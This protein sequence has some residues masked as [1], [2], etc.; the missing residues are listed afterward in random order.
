MSYLTPYYQNKA[1]AGQTYTTVT[2]QTAAAGNFPFL[3]IF[4][5]SG[6]GKTLYVYAADY[7]GP[8]S[9]QVYLCAI[10]AALSGGGQPRINKL[11][12]GPVSIA[13]AVGGSLS[14]I[15]SNVIAVGSA[16]QFKIEN[17]VNF[18]D[19]FICPPGNGLALL[20]NAAASSGLF[21]F[22]WVEE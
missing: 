17:I 5:P 3:S 2:N 10:T 13:S 8:S 18:N 16:Q 11:P 7:S 22:T 9:L 14:V 20:N 6:S 12:G 19:A 15:P 1:A 4:N 21:T